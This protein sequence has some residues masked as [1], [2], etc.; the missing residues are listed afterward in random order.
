MWAS[1]SEVY[2]NPIDPDA[3]YPQ[4]HEYYGYPYAFSDAGNLLSDVSG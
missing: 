1:T 4:K 3:H 2:S